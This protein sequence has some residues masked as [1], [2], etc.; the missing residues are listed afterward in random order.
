M[1]TCKVKVHLHILSNRKQKKEIKLPTYKEQNVI[2]RILE[3]PESL[4][5]SFKRLTLSLFSSHAMIF[6]FPFMR[7]AT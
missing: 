6:P 3:A 7:A 2:R 5:V 1:S 4:I